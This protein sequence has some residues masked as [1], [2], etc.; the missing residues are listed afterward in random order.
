MTL[1]QLHPAPELPPLPKRI[2]G[3]T[4]R[5]VSTAPVVY[6]Q[7][8]RRGTTKDLLDDFLTAC[9]V[10]VGA[11]GQ[12]D[13]AWGEDAFRAS[14]RVQQESW[15]RFCPDCL[16]MLV[17]RDHAE[18]IETAGTRRLITAARAYQAMAPVITAAE[19]MNV[20]IASEVKRTVVNAEQVQVSMAPSQS[21]A[22]LMDARLHG[23]ARRAGR[24][25][26]R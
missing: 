20:H 12:H 3:A 25:A 13:L 1:A 2:P 14:A 11:P 4:L 7:H 16:A 24:H 6:T 26:R 23:A 17:E 10:E 21:A 19:V 18:A 9:G 8:I 22:L 15:E 5:Q